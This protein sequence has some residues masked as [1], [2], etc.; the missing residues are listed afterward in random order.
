M[1][2]ATESG[3]GLELTLEYASEL[4]EAATAQRLIGHF[5]TLLGNV[6][7]DPAQPLA[8][9]ELLA[10]AEKAQLDTFNATAHELPPVESVLAL[11]DDWVRTTPGAPCVVFRDATLSYADVDRR[12]NAIAHWL[13]DRGVQRDELVPILMDPCIEQLSAVLGVLKSGAAFLP[14]DIAYPIGR[15]LAILEDSGAKVLLT[16]AD[17]A[18]ELGFAGPTLDIASAGERE[19]LHVTIKR[20][21]AAYVI[22]TSGSTGKPKGVVIEH[23]SLLNFTAWYNDYNAIQPG[24]ALSKYAGPSFDTSISELFPACTTGG[25]LVMV[26][27]ELR[28]ELAEFS[29]YFEKHQVRIAFLPT[30]FGE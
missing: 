30:Q 7:R 12:A 17:H 28:L 26:P 16:R 2:T 3:D 24:E 21:H 18:A 19:P 5:A 22:Y 9:L 23:G 11:F 8:A 4:F 25:V 10:A 1:L 29:A 6:I 20:S 27:A 14:I 13:H 15:K